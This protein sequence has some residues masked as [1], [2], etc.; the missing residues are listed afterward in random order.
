M[1]L[2]TVL[3]ALI[4]VGTLPTT[5][6]DACDFGGR[7]IR[8]VVKR[9]IAQLGRCFAR[10]VEY[11]GSPDLEAVLHFTIAPS[12]RVLA[13]RTTGALDRRILR[14]L[15]AEVRTWRFRVD[16]STDKVTYPLRFRLTSPDAPPRPSP[17]D[18]AIFGAPE[19]R[20]F[21]D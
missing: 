13:S 10:V 4:A 7:K 2:R 17:V 11:R 14:C 3:V 18:V 1:W 9:R 8:S 15:D 20:G 16:D 5:T 12:G 6:A 21:D 19:R